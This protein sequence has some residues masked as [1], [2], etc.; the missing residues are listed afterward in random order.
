METDISSD[1]SLTNI[2]L[3]EEMQSQQPDTAL[4]ER[5]NRWAR[6]R[7]ILVWENN[8]DGSLQLRFSRNFTRGGNV[9][10]H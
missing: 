3:A 9:A 10:R 5:S 7:T 6:M 4:L 2:R 1:V 8:P